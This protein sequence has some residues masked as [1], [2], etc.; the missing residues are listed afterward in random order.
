LIPTLSLPYVL[1]ADINPPDITPSSSTNRKPI[2]GA[3]QAS[4]QVNVFTSKKTHVRSHVEG[5]SAFA[6][7]AG[8]Y[9]FQGFG[10]VSNDVYKAQ[11]SARREREDREAPFKMALLMEAEEKAVCLKRKRARDRKRASRA[12][13][14]EADI[15]EGKRDQDGKLPAK[16][17]FRSSFIIGCQPG[18]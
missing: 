9:A 10:L 13:K 6:K 12:H 8:L 16:V 7:K 14:L 5:S 11:R 15:A 1:S 18:I 17:R 4:L 3:E 2:G